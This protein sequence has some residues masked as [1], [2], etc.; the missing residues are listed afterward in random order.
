MTETSPDRRPPKSIRRAGAIVAVQGAAAIVIA[1][2]LVIR[3][4]EGAG[5]AFISSYGTAAWFAILGGGVLAGGIALITGRRWGRAI[6]VVAE[7]LLLPVSY[8]LIVDSGQPGYGVP[9]LLVA[10][11]ALALLFSPSSVRWLAAE[12]APDAAPPEV[13]DPST[14]SSTAQ[15]PK[16][17][18]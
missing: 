7:I 6:A 3:G 9:L 11:A 17:R 8:A 15:K 14:P 16:R 5:E 2:V 13:S 4:F 18:R 10:L 12:Y 1:L